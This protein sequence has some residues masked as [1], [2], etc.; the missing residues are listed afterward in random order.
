MNTITVG[1][2]NGRPLLMCK[3]DLTEGGGEA[4]PA[5]SRRRLLSFRREFL[6]NLRD[7]RENAPRLF[8]KELKIV[9]F[10]IFGIDKRV[11]L[12]YNPFVHVRNSNSQLAKCVFTGGKASVGIFLALFT[13]GKASVGIFLALFTGGK[14]PAGMIYDVFRRKGT[15]KHKKFLKGKTQQ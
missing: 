12:C 13:D 7:L 9:N 8:T 11:V 4:F 10:F 14:A 1:A 6:V 15:G 2:T 3:K 5:R